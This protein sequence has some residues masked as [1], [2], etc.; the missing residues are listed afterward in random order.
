[1]IIAIALRAEKLDVR[2]SRVPV[3]PSSAPDNKYIIQRPDFEGDFFRFANYCGNC[4][5]H[6][7][8]IRAVDFVSGKCLLR[9]LGDGLLIDERF[10]HEV[11][12]SRKQFAKSFKTRRNEYIT[13]PTNLLSQIFGFMVFK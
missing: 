12:Y 2:L 11:M 1:M 6:T 3:Q 9:L 5:P 8:L 10:M 13:I 7:G 4:K